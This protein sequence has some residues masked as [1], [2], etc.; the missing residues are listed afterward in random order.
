MDALTRTTNVDV[1]LAHTALIS[2]IRY[3]SS[4]LAVPLSRRQQYD[5]SLLAEQ[6]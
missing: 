3:G 2:F 5:L 1:C 6:R 4:V